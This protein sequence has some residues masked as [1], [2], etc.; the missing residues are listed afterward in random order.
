[1]SARQPLLGLAIAVAFS[2]GAAA[3]AVA[4]SSPHPVLTLGVSSEQAGPA[5]ASVRAHLAETQTTPGHRAQV[6]VRV[7]R[8]ARSS[9]PVRFPSIPANS[10]VLRNPQP[11]GPQSFW[12]SDG[13][14]HLCMYAPSSVLPC[15]TVVAPK[16][17]STALDPVSIAASV[18]NRLG[19][20]PGEIQTSP[21][22]SGLTGADSWFWLYPAPQRRELS[23]SLAGET[24]TVTADPMVEWQFGDGATLDGGP[25][26]PYESDAVLAAA[27]RHVYQTRCLPGDQGRVPY[28]LASCGRDGYGVEALVVWQVSFSAVGPVARSGT[29]PTRT[30]E[31]S[32]IYPVSEARAFLGAN[33]GT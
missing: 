14:G 31:S 25:G 26:V 21:A 33:G 4:Q 3:S 1:M 24:V 9:L 13:S 8:A 20:T 12:Y 15:F 11:V 28:V 5:R 19:L 10:P 16:S 17:G 7:T 30:T 27:V 22:R 29:L 32:L 2:L 23:V 6:A 18:A